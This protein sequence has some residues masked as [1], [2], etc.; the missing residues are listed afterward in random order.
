MS[1]QQAAEMLELL[2]KIAA[3]LAAILEVQARWE[4]HG[5]PVFKV[6]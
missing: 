3:D 6:D 4:G 2:R 5:V 1:E